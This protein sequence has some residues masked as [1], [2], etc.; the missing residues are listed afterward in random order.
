MKPFLAGG[1]TL[2]VANWVALGVAEELAQTDQERSMLEAAM[3][4]L[5]PPQRL[6]LRLRYQ[7]DLTLEEIARLT[8]MPDPFRANRQVQAALEALAEI[9]KFQSPSSAKRRDASV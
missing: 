3:A 5:P 2:L 4:R 1:I 8:G 7:Q 9:V 6:L